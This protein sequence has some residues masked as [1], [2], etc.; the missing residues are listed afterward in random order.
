MEISA[1]IL[2]QRVV[3]FYI[4]GC[5]CMNALITDAGILVACKC[6][7]TSL[8]L[9]LVSYSGFIDFEDDTRSN[10]IDPGTLTLLGGAQAYIYDCF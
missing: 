9:E 6:S 3:I 4:F 7:K 10:M 8:N 1:L 2:H 5:Y